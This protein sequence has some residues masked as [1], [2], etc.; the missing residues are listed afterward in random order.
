MTRGLGI[1]MIDLRHA[2]VTESL[3]TDIVLQE[4]IMPFGIARETAKFGRFW[5]Q[6]MANRP[7]SEAL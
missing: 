3:L 2:N 6:L 4:Y 5:W 1:C 7:R